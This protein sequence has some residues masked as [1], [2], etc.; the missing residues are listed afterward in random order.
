MIQFL[1][2]L[3]KWKTL[4]MTR[5]DNSKKQNQ[6]LCNLSVNRSLARENDNDKLQCWETVLQVA[7]HRLHLGMRM[8]TMMVM[9]ML[10]F[11]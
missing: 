7:E 4:A 10:F 9:K 2:L 5:N 11:K 1:S 3:T 6:F 8:M